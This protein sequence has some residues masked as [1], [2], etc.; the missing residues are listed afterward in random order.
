MGQHV[1]V[2][3]LAIGLERGDMVVLDVRASDRFA[4]AHIPGSWPAT[5]AALP[6]RLRD[7]ADGLF[8]RLFGPGP[9]PD[10]HD[11]QVCVVGDGDLDREA[12]VEMLGEVGLQGSIVTGGVPAW[13]AAGRPLNWAV[14]E[15]P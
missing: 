4:A 11:V 13:S 12:L 14:G 10:G 3:E 8:T 7:P 9:A 1:S 2:D 5:L 15:D 6:G